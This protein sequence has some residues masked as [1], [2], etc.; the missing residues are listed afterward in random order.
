MVFDVGLEM[1]G[2]LIDALGQK[3]HLHVGA[4]RVLLVHAERL[5]FLEF[6]HIVLSVS[7]AVWASLAGLASGSLQKPARDLVPP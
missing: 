1:L 3:R 7:R 6:C 2:E 5:D 4:A